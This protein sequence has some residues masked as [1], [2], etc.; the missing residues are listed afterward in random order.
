VLAAM[1]G[2]L[3]LAHALESKK[4]TAFIAAGVLLGLSVLMKQNGIFFFAFGLAAA[5]WS[6]LEN[7]PRNRKAAISRSLLVAAGGAIPFA[8]LCVVF[9]AQG[10]LGKFWFWAFQY[11]KEYV[12]EM[13]V[14][15]AWGAFA[16]AVATITQAD[17]LVWILALAGV[18]LLWLVPWTR[19]TRITL[20]ALLAA[21]FIALLPGFY[22]REHY[23]ILL[24]PATALF[25][26]VT[27]LSAQRLLTA[28]TT[29]HRSRIVVTG[30]F[31]L[32][33][34]AFVIKESDYLF[35]MSTPE[36]IRDRYGANPFPEATEIARYIQQHSGS[37][38]RVAVLGSEPEIYFYAK[39]HSATGY[40]Y[41]YALME[42]QPYSQRMQDEMISE[43][44]SAHPKYAVF[45]RIPPSWLARN[46]QE[47]ILT[48]SEKYLNQCYDLVGIADIL[49][50]TET[51]YVW[52]A[53]AVVYKPRSQA[54]IYTFKA[55]TDARCTVPETSSD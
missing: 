30:V 29:P 20:T 38:D 34:S 31:F 13:S 2:L 27:A 15:D 16:N 33:V 6:A 37:D 39:R 12:S 44:T 3:V 28:F 23:F 51:K 22:F 47:K 19:H 24:L 26:G 8:I 42:Q 5:A 35:S 54:Y 50:K 53:E 43:V 7:V 18:V 10:V 1:G 4:G 52:D 49:S 17:V 32:A 41:T 11:A 14:S 9:L 48:W 46:T 45:V 55:K 36:L 40:I 25:C 21:S